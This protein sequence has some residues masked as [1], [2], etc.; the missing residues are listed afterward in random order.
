M[1]LTLILGKVALMY[2]IFL[3]TSMSHSLYEASL[4][5][6]NFPKAYPGSLYYGVGV[7]NSFTAI[8]TIHFFLT[9]SNANLASLQLIANRA[10]KA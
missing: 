1:P 5:L 4:P 10:S 7:M 9:L 2:F 3:V 6:R 8:A